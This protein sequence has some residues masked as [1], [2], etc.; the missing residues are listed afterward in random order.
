VLPDG[1]TVFMLDGDRFAFVDGDGIVFY[2]TTPDR[3][4]APG[5]Y[6]RITSGLNTDGATL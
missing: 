2:P 1:R 4:D 6:V 5:T 3:P